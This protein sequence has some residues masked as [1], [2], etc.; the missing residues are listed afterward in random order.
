MGSL[1][2]YESFAYDDGTLIPTFYATRDR[3]DGVL[4]RFTPDEA[5]MRCYLATNDYDRWCTLDSGSIDYLYLAEGNVVEWTTD[6]KK[7]SENAK[8]LYPSSEGIDVKDGILYFTSKEDKRLVIVNLR[9]NTYSYS[10]TKSG[11]FDNQPDQL[12]IVLGRKSEMLLICEDGGLDAG[13]HGR[14]LRGNYFTILYRDKEIDTDRK[15]E[16]TTG[17]GVSPDF[18]HL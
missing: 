3:K 14:D 4:T 10:S 1:G 7:A 17:L 13:L 8:D 12:D 16:E 18:K 5:A 11:A 15:N 9:Q 2:Y 6:E